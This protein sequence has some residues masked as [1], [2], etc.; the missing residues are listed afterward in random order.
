M[1]NVLLEKRAERD[2]KKLSA[3]LFYRIMP[4]IQALSDNPRPSGCLKLKN[5]LQDY[6][7]RVGDYRILYEID[8]HNQVVK[9]MRVRHRRESYR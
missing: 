3:D 4:I 8:D 6:R 9:I 2:L 5:T 7:I 1:Y